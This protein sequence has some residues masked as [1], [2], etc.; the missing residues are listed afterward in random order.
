M[1]GLFGKADPFYEIFKVVGQQWKMVHKSEVVKK[2]L[3]PIW[4]PFKIQS[5]KLCNK[6]SSKG[7]LIKVWDWDKNSSPDFIGQT[8][9][10]LSQLRKKPTFQLKRPKKNKIYGKLNVKGFQSKELP[11]FLDYVQGGTDFS[12]MVAIDFTGIKYN[13]DIIYYND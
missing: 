4:V 2:T 11:S 7:I 3:D 6:D 9:T 12:L 5:S 1:D 10:T 13:V 8:Q